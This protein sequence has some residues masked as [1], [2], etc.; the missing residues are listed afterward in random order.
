MSSEN[1]S[2]A[3]TTC[4]IMRFNGMFSRVM[5]SEEIKMPHKNTNDSR[6]TLKIREAA[7]LAGCGD[8]AIRNG[9]K[10]GSIPHLRFGRLILI[11]RSAF[12]RYLDNAGQV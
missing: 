6:L 3:M 2:R 12:L 11:P 7:R 5:P 10:D 9:V 8:K 4:N 1:L